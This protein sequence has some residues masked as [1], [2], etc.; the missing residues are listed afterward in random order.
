MKTLK[1]LF[2]LLICI[3]LY[4]FI[5][6]CQADINTEDEHQIVLDP[7]Y[8][9]LLASISHFE[10]VNS[11]VIDA[12]TRKINWGFVVAADATP[13][14]LG[15]RFGKVGILAGAVLG[16]MNSFFIAIFDNDNNEIS[17]DQGHLGAVWE[18][19]IAR[20]KELDIDNVE[21]VGA[22]HNAVLQQLLQESVNIDYSIISDWE[23]FNI[24]ALKVAE[25][26]PEESTDISESQ[27]QELMMSFP[28]S[29]E[30][31]DYDTFESAC[32][33][34]YPGFEEDF[35]VASKVLKTIIAQETEDQLDNYEKGIIQLIK[36]SSIPEES[37]KGLIGTVSVQKA[38]REFWYD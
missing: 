5:S 38:S 30:Y 21:I 4:C 12:P 17:E 22:V 34:D 2:K 19:E 37:K 35:T 8:E 1:V 31:R 25:Y 18:E 28:D 6:S 32:L 16:I 11:F 15:S 3:G 20:L 23:L 29:R 7:A 13:I 27:F 26:L 24:T 14:I 10:Q 9:D 33:N 36:D